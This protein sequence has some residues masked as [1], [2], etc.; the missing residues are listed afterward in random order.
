M[1]EKRSRT[2]GKQADSKASP[3]THT[4]VG[5]AVFDMMD[6]AIRVLSADQRG[7]TLASERDARE[8]RDIAERL[9]FLRDVLPFPGA[10]ANHPKKLTRTQFYLGRLR[11]A[12]NAICSDAREEGV[13]GDDRARDAALSADLQRELGKFLAK[14]DMQGS[15]S[16]LQV[17]EAVTKALRSMK[18]QTRERRAPV[19]QDL[20]WIEST[21]PRRAYED[22]ALSRR[23]KPFSPNKPLH[24]APSAGELLRLVLDDLPVVIPGGHGPSS[25]AMYCAQVLDAEP[26]IAARAVAANERLTYL[27]TLLGVPYEEAPWTA[28]RIRLLAQGHGGEKKPSPR[29]LDDWRLAEPTPYELPG[30][31]QWQAMLD[32]FYSELSRPEDDMPRLMRIGQLFASHAR[33]AQPESGAPVGPPGPLFRPANSW[34]PAGATPEDMEAMERIPDVEIYRGLDAVMPMLMHLARH[35]LESGEPSL[36]PMRMPMSWKKQRVRKYNVKIRT[37]TNPNPDAPSSGSA[38]SS[39]KSKQVRPRRRGKNR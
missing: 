10:D 3:L 16:A 18:E 31:E 26:A 23:G 27:A 6:L 38:Q 13:D 25:T 22:G 33:L 29:T 14:L 19:D 5:R 2:R 4:G 1:G 7:R 21:L 34:Y 36:T 11:N 39:V 37:K 35:P 9:E 8:L 24:G 30:R 12:V 28:L 20:D 15:V 17:E 32:A